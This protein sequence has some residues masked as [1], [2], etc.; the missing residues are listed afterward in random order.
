[1]P[2]QVV[3]ERSGEDTSEV[4]ML[5]PEMRIKKYIIT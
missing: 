1:M 4:A 2:N 3:S 5:V